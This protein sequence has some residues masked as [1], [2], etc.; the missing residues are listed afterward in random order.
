MI[1][2]IHS[3]ESLGL[4]DGPG[5]R[6][7]V[8]FQGC[9][10]RCVY[11]HNPDTWSIASG[12][13]ITPKQLVNKAIRF[14]SYFKSSQGGVTCS[15]GEPLLQPDF[16]I[17]FLKLCKKNGIHT[18]IDTAGVG[19]GKYEEILKYTDLV[20]LDIKH[21][22]EKG[23]EKIAGGNYDEFR[24]FVKVLKK[25]DIDLWIRHVVVPTMTDSESHINSLRDIIGGFDNVKKIE[26]LPYHTLGVNKYKKMDI[27]YK[28]EGVKPMDKEKIKV[29]EK[30]IQ[31]V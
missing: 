31:K 8:F 9:N 30:I 16:L 5:V 22:D 23:Y 26:L 25:T 21:I 27:P 3:I 17:E 13:E 10:L 14:K 20:L 18:A 4:N 19:I 6:F 1:G 24:R 7:V 15:G 28:L 2:K 29:L 12:E 11:C